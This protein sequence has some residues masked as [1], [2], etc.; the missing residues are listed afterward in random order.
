MS[1][2]QE[3]RR[4]CPDRFRIAT[5][6]RSRYYARMDTRY[7]STTDSPAGSL[8]IAVTTDGRVTGVWFGVVTDAEEATASVR[9]HGSTP[10]WDPEPARHVVAQLGEYTER[11]RMAFDV[12]LDLRGSDWERRVWQALLT[13]PYGETRSYGQIATMLGDPSKARAVGWANAANPIP[14]IV[15]CHRVIGANR[16]LT[17]FGGGIQAK[18]KLLAHEGAMLPGFD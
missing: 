7:L 2:I 3:R 17:G 6:S 4:I 14:V 12:E 10:V 9:R 13:I 5:L 8:H 18:I 1:T 16:N 15:P 11:T